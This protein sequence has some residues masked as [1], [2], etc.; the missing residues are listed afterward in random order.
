M[1][2]SVHSLLTLYLKRVILKV[3]LEKDFT[4]DCETFCR[5]IP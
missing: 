4:H 5:S 2:V 3:Y 1:D